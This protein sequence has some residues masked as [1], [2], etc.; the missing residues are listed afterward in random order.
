MLTRDRSLWNKFILTTSPLV[1]KKIYQLII[2]ILAV[3][4]YYTHTTF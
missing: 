4:G 2:A 1:L 3:V